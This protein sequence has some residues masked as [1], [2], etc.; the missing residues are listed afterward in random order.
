LRKNDLL[1]QIKQAGMELVDK[2]MI[3]QTLLDYGFIME[4]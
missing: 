1:N 4:N 3:G 2:I